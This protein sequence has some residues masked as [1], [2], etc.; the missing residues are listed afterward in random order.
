VTTWGVTGHMDLGPATRR[1][2]AEHLM[3]ELTAELQPGESL[4]GLSCLAPGADQVF[5]WVVAALG[6][7]L[8]VVRPCARIEETLDG[9]DLDGMRA[10]AALAVDTIELPFDEPSNAAYAAANDEVLARSDVLVA[11]YD[12]GPSAGQGGTAELVGLARARGK[13]VLVVWPDGAVRG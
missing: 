13:R 12:D 11:I 6:G 9:R 10:A 5:A 2:V 8:V 1:L 7:N 3:A 4:V